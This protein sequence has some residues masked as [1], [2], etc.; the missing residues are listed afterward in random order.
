MPKQL[1]NIGAV[2]ATLNCENWMTGTPQFCVN[3]HRPDK[4][5]ISEWS[6]SF[7][8]QRSRIHH[9][10]C[11]G[12]IERICSSSH[13]RVGVPNITVTFLSTAPSL[14]LLIHIYLEGLG[15]W[16]TNT[17]GG[18]PCRAGM[19]F[20]SKELGGRAWCSNVTKPNCSKSYSRLKYKQGNM[21]SRS[22]LS[23]II[24]QIWSTR[25]FVGKT[26]FVGN[27]K[28]FCNPLEPQPLLCCSQV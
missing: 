25:I 2:T 19:D 4:H 23:K 17:M 8:P 24:L 28:D 10:S 12:R 11:R 15:I 13:C 27:T 9:F 20:L 1:T 22:L 26:Q 16:N 21:R 3:E 18:N 7:C 6:N 5:W 14:S